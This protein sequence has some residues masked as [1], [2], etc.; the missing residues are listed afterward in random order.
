M[1]AVTMPVRPPA[2]AL[3]PLRTLLAAGGWGNGLVVLGV[4]LAPAL[5]ALE[6]EESF[7]AGLALAAV[8]NMFW[9]MIAGGRLVGLFN[10]SA[11]LRAPGVGRRALACGATALVAGV[12]LPA[13]VIALAGSGS[14]ALAT[15]VLAL[16]TALGLFWVSMPPWLMWVLIGLGATARWL[17]PLPEDLDGKALLAPQMVALAALLLLAL[18]LACWMWITRQRAWP[19]TWSMPLAVALSTASPRDAMQ[20]WTPLTAD[21]PVDRDLRQSPQRAMGVALGPGFGRNTLRNVLVTQAPNIA[22]AAFWLLL[23][24]GPGKPHVGLT[25][26]PFMVISAGLV[27]ILRLQA[28]FWRPAQGLHELALLPGLPPRPAVALVAQ[29]LAQLPVRVLPA[30]AVMLGFGVLVD[31]PP[32]YYPMLACTSAGGLALLSGA[33]LLCLHTSRARWASVV[34]VAVVALAM[35]ASA[36]AGMIRGPAPWL[37]PAWGAALLAGLLLHV[38]ALRRL[39]AMPHPWLR[40]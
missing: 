39:G 13:Q 6:F 11:G 20:G 15:A 21:T 31:A 17:P 32:A 5:A 34:A 8:M 25:F 18:C 14:P 16:G 26:A 28:L 38:L 19:S 2:A 4:V 33:G 9:A 36:M 27:P 24:S 10:T 30:L 40:H 22:V 3:A 1:S 7:T 23:A 12:L 35:L 29:L 37:Y